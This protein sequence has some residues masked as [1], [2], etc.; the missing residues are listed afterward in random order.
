MAGRSLAGLKPY[1]KKEAVPGTELLTTMV[2]LDGLRMVR[3][4]RGGSAEPFNGGTGK[5]ASGVILSDTWAEWSLTPASCYRA[6]G[7]VA[8]SRIAAPVTTTPGGGTLSRQH[9]FTL[10]PNAIDT[11]VTYTLVWTDGTI[12]FKSSYNAFQSLGFT[13][14]RGSV[15]V[16]SNMIGRKPI[17]TSTI[18]SSPTSVALKPIQPNLGDVWIDSTWATLGT[19]QYLA[20]Y[21]YDLQLGDKYDMDAPINSSI[22]SFATLP[23]KED[24]SMTLNLSVAVDTAGNALVA[25]YDVGTMIA[26]RYKILGPIIETTI[27]FSAQWDCLA[28]IT[29]VGEVTAAPNSNIATIPLTCSIA[30]DG[31]NALTLT[32]VNDI[33]SY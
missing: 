19:T 12:G 33:I 17:V 13:A 5:T 4:G 31:T 24:Q 15:E 25:N 7:F 30:T 29:E 3:L 14:E 23:E 26:V 16:S 28:V 22:S 10:N 27:P 6:L 8:A 32:L 18:P 9:V 20:A 21:Q 1:I 11:F 2:Q